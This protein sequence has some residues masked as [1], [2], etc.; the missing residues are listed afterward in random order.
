ML[1][2]WSRPVWPGV[3]KGGEDGRRPLAL[4][5]GHSLRPLALWAGHPINGYM[6]VLGVAC[7]RG[8]VEGL[9][10]AGPVENSGSPFIR[11]SVHLAVR[12][13]ICPAMR[14]CFLFILF[15]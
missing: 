1:L 11:S 14:N 12:P 9:G 7:P 2:L 3:Y 4:W 15:L 13:S 6:A 10:M 8:G 5:A